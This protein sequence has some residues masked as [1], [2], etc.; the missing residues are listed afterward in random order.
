[1]YTIYVELVDN[2]RYFIHIQPLII[3][4]TKKKEDLCRI[5]NFVIQELKHAHRQTRLVDF[6]SPQTIYDRCSSE[7]VVSVSFRTVGS[8]HIDSSNYYQ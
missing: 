8:C 5:I 2:I 6:L 7:N 1:M 4:V 3:V